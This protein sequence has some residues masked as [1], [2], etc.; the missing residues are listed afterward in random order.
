[1]NLR[2]AVNTPVPKKA[3]DDQDPLLIS[4]IPLALAIV[5]TVCK[6]FPSP[7]AMLYKTEKQSAAS[8]MWKGVYMMP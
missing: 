2:G 3:Y 7:N 1:M 4:F 6:V 8:M 5:P